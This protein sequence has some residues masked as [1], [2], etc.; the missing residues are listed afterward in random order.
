MEIPVWIWLSA[1]LA[2]LC[3]LPVQNL[4]VRYL[5]PAYPFL[6]LIGGKAFGEIW[7]GTLGLKTQLGKMAAFGLLFWHAASVMAAFPGMIS[8]FND[9]V[10]PER[11]FYYLGIPTWIG[12]RMS[13][14]WPRWVWKKV[15]KISNSP[16]RRSRPSTL[17]FKMVVL[18][19]AGFDRAPT[20][21]GLRG[22]RVFPAD[23]PGFLPGLDSHRYRMDLPSGSHRQNWGIL[24]LF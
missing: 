18:D 19:R 15:G 12:A 24:V 13:K 2:F 23:C 21:N 14:P 11:K 4:G 3:I 17:W 7:K 9:L 6:L 22:Q 16:R 10:P 5:L 1:F 20:R 8:Y